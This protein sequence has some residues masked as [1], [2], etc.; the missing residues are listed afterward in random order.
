M[1]DYR[2]IEIR[3]TAVFTK[4]IRSL[5]DRR[6]RLAIAK[7]ID[8]LAF[9]HEGDAKSVGSGVRELRI[10]MG[11]G[12]R[13]YFT[14]RGDRIIILLCGGDKGSQVRDIARAQALAEEFEE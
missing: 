11:P 1:G 3:Q 13:V 7:R 14:R 4:W 10:H 6:T 5:A 12:Y 9:G 2:M 8:R